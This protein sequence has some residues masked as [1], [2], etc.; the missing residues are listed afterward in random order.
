MGEGL[1]KVTPHSITEARRPDLGGALGGCWIGRSY[2][3]DGLSF[4]GLRSSG[5]VKGLEVEVT[6]VI[7][8]STNHTVCLVLPVPMN[9]CSYLESRLPWPSLP[10]SALLS[11]S[12]QD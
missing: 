1:C 10:A 6:T 12:N 8:Q 3:K 7:S 11:T 5:A 4:S 9:T 2:E